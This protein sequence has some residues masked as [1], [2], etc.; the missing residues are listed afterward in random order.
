VVITL[1]SVFIIKLNSELCLLELEL[2]ISH[3][4]SPSVFHIVTRQ[5]LY[6]GFGLRTGFTEC[7]HL[8]TTS[9]NNNNKV[10]VS[11]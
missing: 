7:L 9:N 6:I 10:N 3:V 11:L 2:L 1:Y 4:L 5:R 8:A